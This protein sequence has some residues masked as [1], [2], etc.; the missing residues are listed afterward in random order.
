MS[1]RISTARGNS[2]DRQ[3]KKKKTQNHGNS[4]LQQM[5]TKA[6]ES[7]DF[8]NSVVHWSPRNLSCKCALTTA[9]LHKKNLSLHL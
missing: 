6:V 1:I 7:K 9:L 3:L 4:K 5:R 8:A 2:D